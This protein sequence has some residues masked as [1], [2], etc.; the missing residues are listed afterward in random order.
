MI[1][2]LVVDDSKLV[3]EG[4]KAMFAANDDIDVIGFAENGSKAIE[5]I[6]QTQQ[7]P[8]IALVDV[9]MPVMNGIE[10]TKQISQ[11]FPKI[12]VIILTSFENDPIV[13]KAV[14]VGAKGYLLKNMIARD[15]TLAILGVSRGSTHFAPGIIDSL[16][17]NIK[18]TPKTKNL[19]LLPGKL[20][21]V[22]T[23]SHQTK[24]QPIQIKKA[25]VKKKP[26]SQKP[27]F[28]HGDW[29]TIV[30]CVIVLSQTDGMGHH[31]AHAGL[32][33]L[34]LSLVARPI[35]TR[36]NW[37]LKHR[38]TIGIFAFAA[39]VAHA[40]Y[41]T[42]KVLN[43]DLETMLT[44][45]P[46]D[47]WGI[48]IGIVSLLAMTPAAITS[49]QF[50]Q[51]KLGKKWRQ[52]HLLT[53]PSL[54]LAVLHTV[55]VGPH[56]MATFN[57]DTIDYLRVF[58]VVTGGILVLLMRKKNFWSMLDFNLLNKLKKLSVNN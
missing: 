36:W 20:Y 15:L 14:A 5:Y 58:G 26:K 6:K 27:L 44:L 49:F 8:D 34:M 32:F 4:L 30:L 38:R 13:L 41:A 12:K 18:E 10:T 28:E 50:F 52:I 37:P 54:A 51:R 21:N 31:L 43:F 45:S 3:Y 48:G 1:R 24:A 7:K 19:K 33:F 17:E 9:F 47:K 55:M 23:P 11:L 29:L 39:A 35:K 25:K 57:M 42:F 2:V 22:E 53:V 16:V 46:I 56:Y 40:F